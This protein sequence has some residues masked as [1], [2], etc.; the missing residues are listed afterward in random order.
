MRTL[1]FLICAMLPAA[2]W[3]DAPVRVGF[4][5]PVTQVDPL[6]VNGQEILLAED[7]PVVS[8]IGGDG[9]L[10]VGDVLQIEAEFDGDRFSATRVVRQFLAV[11]PVQIAK[12]TG[13]SVMGSGFRGPGA[14]GVAEGQWIAVAG[15]WR[16]RHGVISRLIPLNDPAIAMTGGH[17]NLPEDGVGPI[18]IGQTAITGL[19]AVPSK[20]GYWT[21]IGAA[22]AD[23]IRANVL[24][25]GLFA[26]DIAFALVAGFASGPI[27]SETYEI[28]GTGIVGYAREAQM[29]QRDQPQL[30]CVAGGKVSRGAPADA[31]A[32]VL[33][34]FD[35]WGCPS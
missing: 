30:F 35:V 19:A 4:L 16:E 12:D 23:S 27:A 26:D 31:G 14:D 32:V 29:P 10:R 34:L 2:L 18:R 7:V 13:I 20:T 5:G 8:F 17:P 1:L 15:Q 33:A 24:S 3:A 6:M 11:G 9:A 22:G 25:T 21:V 28:I